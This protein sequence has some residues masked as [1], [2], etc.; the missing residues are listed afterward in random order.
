MVVAEPSAP[1]VLPFLEAI[2][3]YDSRPREL[4]PKEMLL[5]YEDGW[6]FVGVLAEPSAE[7]LTWIRQ[8]VA[9]Y[10]ST[11]AP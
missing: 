7:E 8:L 6:R 11:I 3:W 4:S 1:S 9:R 2:S 5:R 10:G